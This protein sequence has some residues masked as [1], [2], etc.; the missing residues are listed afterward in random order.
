MS[1]SLLEVNVFSFLIIC[2]ACYVGF[3][4]L[5]HNN[6][7]QIYFDTLK[8]TSSIAQNYEL[9]STQINSNPYIANGTVFIFWSIV[10]LLVYYL[11][12]F[13]FLSA[14]NVEE[15]FHTLFTRG[16]DQIDLIEH[17]FAGMAI[18]VFAV[19]GILVEVVLFVGHLLPFLIAS[20][21]ISEL[22]GMLTNHGMPLLWSTIGI[23]AYIHVGAVLLRCATLRVRTFL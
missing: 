13:V 7:L 14:R 4:V 3:S 16:V 1:V 19:I 8:S 6:Y 12:Y 21:N 5:N 10:G 22:D 20:V 2:I 15:F 17:A 23:F 11:V 18:R 9:I